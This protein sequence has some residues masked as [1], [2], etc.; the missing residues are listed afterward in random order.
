MLY[1]YLGLLPTLYM[2]S[3]NRSPCAVDPLA[4]LPIPEAGEH[5]ERLKV[6]WAHVCLGDII[7]GRTQRIQK[8]LHYGEDPDSSLWLVD[9]FITSLPPSSWHI[10]CQI[11]FVEGIP[12]SLLAVACRMAKVP[13]RT[14]QL[15]LNY[16]L[17]VGIPIPN[18]S[19]LACLRFHGESTALPLLPF[20]GHV[21]SHV[22]MDPGT[23][24]C[25]GK[26]LGSSPHMYIFD[27]Y[28]LPY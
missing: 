14:I 5:S 8:W 28:Y 13:A 16:S 24:T 26:W 27:V 19:R 1:S 12:V 18:M 3:T 20:T 4:G 22:C 25:P 15:Y 23:G 11:N 7:P 2:H 10:P 21:L 9:H 6:T 17:K